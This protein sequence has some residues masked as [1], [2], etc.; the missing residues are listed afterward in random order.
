[1]SILTHLDPTPRDKPSKSSGNMTSPDST[2]SSKY[3]Q[4]AQLLF[5]AD[6]VVLALIFKL[7][8]Y[9]QGAKVKALVFPPGIKPGIFHLLGKSVHL[10]TMELLFIDLILE[11][12]YYAVFLHF[13]LDKIS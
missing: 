1:M 5:T 8:L 12:D 7:L 2:S 9:P 10:N 3:Q 13:L 4:K 6:H 11:G